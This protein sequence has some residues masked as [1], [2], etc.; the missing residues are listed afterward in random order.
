MPFR[1]VADDQHTNP[2][3]KPGFPKGETWFFYSIISAAAVEIFAPRSRR[4]PHHRRD[5][6][7]R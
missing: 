7:S 6:R 2:F 5:L 4:D 3:A 1:T